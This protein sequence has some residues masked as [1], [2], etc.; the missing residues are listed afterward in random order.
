M[1][2]KM[3][4]IFMV[5]LAGYFLFENRFRVMNILLGNR[6][7]RRIAVGSIMGLPGVRSKMLHS[8]FSGPSDFQ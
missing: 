5:G 7:L 4:S 8:V 1:V 3:I 2:R 6:Y